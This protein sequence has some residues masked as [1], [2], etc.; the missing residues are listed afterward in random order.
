[1]LQLARGMLGCIPRQRIRRATIANGSKLV[2]T[3]KG[4]CAGWS[5][6][7]AISPF[8]QRIDD[9]LQQQFRHSRV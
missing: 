4:R 5:T 6:T 7:D 2:R 8:D 3:H 9:A 1:M